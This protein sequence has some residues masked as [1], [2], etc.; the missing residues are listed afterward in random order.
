M[1]TEAA[2]DIR[3]I[4]NA[5]D[6][7][8]AEALLAAAIARYEKTAPR[9]SSW[10]ERNLSQGLTVFALPQAHQRLMRTSNGLERVNKEVKRRTRV[11]SIF[12]SEASCLRLVSAVLMEISEDWMS[13]KA[14]LTLQEQNKI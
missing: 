3:A 11:V 4:F 7:A 12:P 9:L 14:Y 13:G 5:P 10:L 6:R 1:K 2:A 8:S